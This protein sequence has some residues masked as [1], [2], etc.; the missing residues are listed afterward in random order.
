MLNELLDVLGWVGLCF[1]IFPGGWGATCFFKQVAKVG[2]TTRPSTF[3]EQL[4]GGGGA[5]RF[6]LSISMRAFGATHQGAPHRKRDPVFV[7]P[8]VLR[9]RFPIFPVQPPFVSHAFLVQAKPE[10]LARAFEPQVHMGNSNQC[11][12]VGSRGNWGEADWRERGKRVQSNGLRC[13]DIGTGTG[14]LA[15]ICRDLGRDLPGA[16]RVGRMGGNG[17]EVQGLCYGAWFIY[18]WEFGVSKLLGLCLC[19]CVMLLVGFGWLAL[20]FGV[21]FVCCSRS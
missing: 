14:L 21:L 6:P 7:L 5:F 9:Y 1:T 11:R 2:Y 20:I 15:L 19:V 3:K 13:L 12:V 18:S 8:H 17:F 4:R 10:L 16:R